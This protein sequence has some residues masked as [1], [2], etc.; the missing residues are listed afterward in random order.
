MHVFLNPKLFFLALD[1]SVT[2]FLKSFSLDDSFI[3]QCNAMQYNAKLQLNLNPYFVLES[4]PDPKL[5]GN[6]IRRAASLCFASVKMASQLRNENLKPDTFKGKALCMGE[7][8][9]VKY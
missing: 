4:S 7:W 6:Q 1:L 8:S 5:A 3:M 9:E 2:L